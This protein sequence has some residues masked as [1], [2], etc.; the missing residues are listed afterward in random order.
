MA[1][2]PSEHGIKHSLSPVGLK[3]KITKRERADEAN[4][5]RKHY[6]P[7]VCLTVEKLDLVCVPPAE[8]YSSPGSTLRYLHLTVHTGV[9]S[10]G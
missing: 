4:G 5:G 3:F 7:P 8:L 10:L 9:E 2:P 1:G 6:A